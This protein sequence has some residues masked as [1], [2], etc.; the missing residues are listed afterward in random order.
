MHAATE[1]SSPPSLTH[2]NHS[3]SFPFPSHPLCG[4]VCLIPA[5]ACLPC[6]LPPRPNPITHAF[7]TGHWP[8]L[9]GI[10]YH[11]HHHSSRHH[12]R[13]STPPPPPLAPTAVRSLLVYPLP[14]KA[15]TDKPDRFNRR[16]QPHRIATLLSVPTLLYLITIPAASCPAFTTL[17]LF[18]L[19]A[20][21]SR[22]Q[23]RPASSHITTLHLHLPSTT[24]AH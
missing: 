21:D 4:K 10:L 20:G 15:W 9:R 1:P 2:L 3:P 7:R 11:H 24:V 12:S 18:L 16:S 5:V 6:P 22:L 13:A 8:A 17:N 14:P 19:P 23:P